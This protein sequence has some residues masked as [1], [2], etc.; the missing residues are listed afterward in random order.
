MEN[1]PSNEQDMENYKNTVAR[2]IYDEIEK[3]NK[4]G[5]GPGAG[6]EKLTVEQIR[7]TL[8]E[9]HNMMQKAASVIKEH[10]TKG[11]A[12][13]VIE[14]IEKTKVQDLKPDSKFLDESDFQ[15]LLELG[16]EIYE[17]GDLEPARSIF[18]YMSSLFPLQ[19]QPY[20]VLATIEWRTKGAEAAATIYRNLIKGLKNPLL[21]LYAGDCIAHAGHK[22]E[23]RTIFNEALE[24][25]DKEE[26]FKAI[27]PEIE[28][29]MKKL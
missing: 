8:D 6:A 19:V 17:R 13:S 18:L 10:D 16:M 9:Y 23:A 3:L 22:D 1:N 7:K 15:A 24:L 29:E 11:K 5:K 26:A 12:R 21:M 28:R 25:C 20:I 4:E 27:R 2:S 14:K